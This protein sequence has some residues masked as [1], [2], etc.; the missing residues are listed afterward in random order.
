MLRS[1]AL[2]LLLPLSAC[3]WLD[4]R[5]VDLHDC[6]VYR[7]HP[8]AL[9]FGADAKVGP[10][11]LAVGG[12]KAEWGEG[13]DTWWQRPGYTLTNHGTGV[14][15]TTLGPIGY[16]QSWSRSLATGTTGNHVL[17]PDAYDDVTSWLLV[18]DVF[19]LDDQSPFA[20]TPA[21]R[22]VDLFG[23]EVGIAPVFW[24]VHVGFN[25]AEFLDFTLGLVGLDIFGDDGVMRPPT[26][27]ALPR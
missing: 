9:G 20:L 3:A 24:Q 12:W 4:H 21:Q 22:V 23:I 6:F 2:L 15:F 7:W 10:L 5:L 26:V 1:L 17:A 14:P 19:D 25:V 11:A 27:P 16:G 13:K 8:D 18:S